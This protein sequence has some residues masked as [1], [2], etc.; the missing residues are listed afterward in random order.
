MISGVYNSYSPELEY[1]LG[2]GNINN[3][4]N[5][6]VKT[7]LSEMGNITDQNLLQEKMKRLLEICKQEIPFIGLYRSQ[8]QIVY[9]T[10]LIGD[11]TPN[12]YSYFY[13]VNGWVRR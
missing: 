5:E 2:E 6:E 8:N 1:F 11:I 3:Y 9:S 7:L 12:N 4:S 10:S 13:H